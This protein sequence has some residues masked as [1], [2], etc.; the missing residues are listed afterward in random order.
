MPNPPPSK[1]SKADENWWPAPLAHVRDAD[2]W[3]ESDVVVAEILSFDDSPHTGQRRAFAALVPIATLEEVRENL[4]KF[5]HEVCASGPHPFASADHPYT[6]KFWMQ[7]NGLPRRSYE[8]LVLSWRSHDKTVLQLDPGF[9]MSY[10][11]TPRSLGNGEICWD[12]PAAPRYDVARVSAPS[13]WNWPAGTAASV[14]IRKDYLQDYLSLRQMALVQVYWELRWDEAD[15]EI[16]AKLGKEEAV[17]IKL[18][19]RQYMLHRSWNDKNIVAVQVWGARVIALPG[20]LPISENDLERNGLIW[21]GFKEPITDAK[22]MAMS[23]GDCVYINDAV[24]GAYEGRPE[25]RV[26]PNSGSVSFGTQWGVGFCDRVGRDL[27][28]VELKKLYE[29]VPPHVTREWHSHAVDAPSKAAIERMAME[30]SI[31]VRAEQIVFATLALGESLSRLAQ[32]VSLPGLQPEAFVGLRRK[33][34]EYHGWW[35]F[36]NIEPVA[37]HIPLNMGE[38]AFLE[39]C[40][41]LQQLIIEGLSQNN[42]RLTLRKLGVPAGEIEKLGS[43][44]LLDLLVRMAQVARQ[45]GLELGLQG[46][47][48]WDRLKDGSTPAEPIG[49][50]FALYDLRTLGGHRSSNR[51][52]E[53]EAH[54]KHF[55]IAPGDAAAGYGK[56]LDHVYDTLA[57][58]LRQT[59]EKIAAALSIDYPLFG[60]IPVS[61]PKTPEGRSTTAPQTANLGGGEPPKRRRRRRGRRARRRNRRDRPES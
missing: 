61:T 2:P 22:A 35:T 44:K 16:K 41:A 53:L 49:H 14:A 48:V 29:G 51:R 12:D 52:G 15:E 26:N 5:E 60:A 7:T 36:E 17:E 33:A 1:G 54:L 28:R 46:K 18:S 55:G 50:L 42:L 6:P 40:K 8:P 10:G 3:A 45:A 25:F 58:E 31:G 57:S 43:L 34:L 30:R 20:P 27:I 39:R 32:A 13:I 37:R 59:G 21:P 4:A 56:V 47:E 38:G 9:L 23:P 24:L 19:D 11:L